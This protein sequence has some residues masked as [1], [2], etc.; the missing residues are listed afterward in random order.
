M[1][2]FKRSGGQDFDLAWRT[3]W[4]RTRFG[5]ECEMSHRQQTYFALLATRE[6]W[7]AA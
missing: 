2:R 6:A 4:E 3:A 5:R 7:E 1:R